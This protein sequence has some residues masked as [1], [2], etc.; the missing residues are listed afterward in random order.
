LFIAVTGANGFVGRN[1]VRELLARGHSVR[2]LV[3]YPDAGLGNEPI[4][5]IAT[6][7]IEAIADW[8]PY[9]ADVDVVAHLAARAHLA[10]R[11]MQDEALFRAVN[12]TA[13]L[14]L[15]RSALRRKTAHFI[16]L[17]SIGVHGSET[18]PGHPFRANSPFNPQNHYA[19]S[20]AE[21]EAGLRALHA[22]G[23]MGITILRPPLIYGP[24][25]RGN[26]RSL[27]ELVRRAPALPFAAI[28]N[29][30]S[31][32]A[33]ENLSAAICTAL[34][35]QATEFSPYPVCDGEDFSLPQ[36]VTMLAEGM[37]KTCRLFPV[38]RTLLMQ[39]A[40]LFNRKKQMQV[41]TRSLQAEDADF[42]NRTGWANAVDP[43]TALRNAAAWLT[44]ALK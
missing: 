24:G 14:S 2:A 7:P 1:L 34:E 8:R 28:D 33:V 25:A 27:C 30:R 15:A 43:K 37:K 29:R 22:E 23:A 31:M 18:E 6:G 40:A 17:S 13:T 32:I 36:L 39:G 12:T 21:A 42:R 20:K 11:D 5:A 35:K 41:L 16:Y 10:D 19:R 4:E 44:N 3:R 26:F 38:P 9:L